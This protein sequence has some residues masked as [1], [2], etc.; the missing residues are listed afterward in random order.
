MEPTLAMVFGGKDIAIAVLTVISGLG[1]GGWLFRKDSGVEERREVSVDAVPQLID[2]GW[3]E[4][5][6]VAKA[7]AI[8]NYSLLTRKIVD[9]MRLISKDGKLLEIVRRSFF[10]MLPRLLDN[11]DDR[12]K[13][14]S[15]VEPYLQQTRETNSKK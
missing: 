3:D 1:I 12:N 7:Y 5:A 13:I 6:E 8:G 15:L 10:K 4:A 11:V 14:L 2:V 9:F